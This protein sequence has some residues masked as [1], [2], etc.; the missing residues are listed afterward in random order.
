MRLLE[1]VQE[2]FLDKIFRFARV[3]KDF[4]ADAVNQASVA[5]EQ[6]TQGLPVAM[7]NLAQQNLVRRYPGR[8]SPV[9]I[10]VYR[11][12]RLWNL[13]CLA[14]RKVWKTGRW[15][16]TGHMQLR[17]RIRAMDSFLH[18]TLVYTRLKIIHSCN[19]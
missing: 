11:I 6:K 3:A 13:F 9:R 17:A 4:L 14:K 10:L 2:E 19:T 12:C 8:P 18:Q 1:D 15:K 5:A 16:G 7:G